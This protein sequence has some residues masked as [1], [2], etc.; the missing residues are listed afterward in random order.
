MFRFR[1]FPYPKSFITKYFQDSTY[2]ITETFE[3]QREETGI[4]N[5]LIYISCYQRVQQC[6]RGSGLYWWKFKGSVH[7]AKRHLF[8]PMLKI[9]STD[10]LRD[11]CWKNKKI[12]PQLSKKKLCGAKGK[13]SLYMEINKI[14][15][16]FYIGNGLYY[17]LSLG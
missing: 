5:Y 10:F 6:T 17:V 15:T 7:H 1:W 12:K 4:K 11:P 2:Q 16:L 14:K 9:S 8:H 13:V 3:N